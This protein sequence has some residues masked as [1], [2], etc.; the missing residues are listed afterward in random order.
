MWEGEGEGR[1]EEDLEHIEQE[2]PDIELSSK[3]EPF[4]IEHRHHQ[5]MLQQ[6]LT[7]VLCLQTIQKFH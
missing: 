7:L 1:E 3:L 4:L 5:R 6:T 2:V